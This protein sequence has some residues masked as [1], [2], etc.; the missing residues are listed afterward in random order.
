MDIVPLL[1]FWH[2]VMDTRCLSS[3]VQNS[4]SLDPLHRG[5]VPRWRRAACPKPSVSILLRSQGTGPLSQKLWFLF[6]INFLSSLLFSPPPGDYFFNLPGSGHEIPLLF[7]DFPAHFILN[8]YNFFTGI[9]A[10]RALIG[11]DCQA[12][13]VL[14][15]ITSLCCI[16]EWRVK[17]LP[18]WGS[19]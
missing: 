5:A 15:L 16:S 7:F 8:P 12:P 19:I 11:R 3:S 2:V 18:V 13:S 9:Y 10:F 6:L 1:L 17:Y 14:C 4:V